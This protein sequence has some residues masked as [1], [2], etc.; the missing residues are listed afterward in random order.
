MNH[1]RFIKSVT[2]MY[3]YVPTHRKKH[4]LLCV[5]YERIA[6]KIQKQRH[7]SNWFF[8]NDTNQ[9]GILWNHFFV[10]VT[11]FGSVSC[12]NKRRLNHQPSFNL[13]R[14]AQDKISSTVRTC[15]WK[16]VLWTH[17]LVRSP[18]AHQCLL[19]KRMVCLGRN[20]L[21]F[22]SS[23]RLRIWSLLQ[24]ETIGVFLL[25]HFCELHTGKRGFEFGYPN[26]W[27]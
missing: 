1:S 25:V 5:S 4:G 16:K 13:S 6:S 27:R 9:L 2:P 8:L 26:K 15:K 7:K 11:L 17:V 3:V 14:R 20:M 24:R 12:G 19:C 10:I 18:R 22:R 23:A 21:T